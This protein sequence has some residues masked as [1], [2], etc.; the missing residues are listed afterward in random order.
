M[1]RGLWKCPPEN[2]QLPARSRPPGTP[3]WLPPFPLSPQGCAH[4]FR[5]LPATLLALPPGPRRLERQDAGVP[6]GH[7][8][9]RRAGLP[10][11]RPL[12][13]RPVWVLWCVIG[14][15]GGDA[16][17]HAA[18]LCL[19]AWMRTF[20]SDGGRTCVYARVCGCMRVSVPV[21]QELAELNTSATPL[22]LLICSVT[23]TYLLGAMYACQVHS[24][25]EKWGLPVAE[26]SGHLTVMLAAPGLLRAGCCCEATLTPKPGPVGPCSLP[27]AP[28]LP[29]RGQGDPRSGRQDRGG[30]LQAAAGGPR[31]VASL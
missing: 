9:E 18:D 30:R 15:M 10:A 7:P 6:R 25:A 1:I 26:P 31:L 3:R 12:E 29:A 17:L 23:G 22:S 8:R 19:F 21:C 24:G 2:L 20:V 14:L 16:A 27:A 28:D 5:R 4:T 11:G 13:R